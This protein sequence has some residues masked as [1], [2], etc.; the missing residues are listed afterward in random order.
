MAKKQQHKTDNSGRSIRSDKGRGQSCRP[1]DKGVGWVAGP[2]PS[3]IHQWINGD[4]QHEDG[5]NL[6]Q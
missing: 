6:Q 4:K 5:L 2:G 1:W 3:G